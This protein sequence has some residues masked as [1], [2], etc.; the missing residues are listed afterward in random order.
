MAWPIC[1][2]HST[3]VPSVMESPIVG[4]FIVCCSNRGNV[5]EIKERVVCVAMT[6][7]ALL[8]ITTLLL[9]R[10]TT[11]DE[12]FDK[13]AAVAI[14]CVADENIFRLIIMECGQKGD[15]SLE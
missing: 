14:R 5:V 2:V 12:T 6:R 8:D 13:A 15:R 11:E 10:P 1:A 9:L 4:T 7:A 3:I